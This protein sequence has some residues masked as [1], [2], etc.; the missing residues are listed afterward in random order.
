MD[1]ARRGRPVHPENAN[2]KTAEVGDFVDYT[3]SSTTFGRCRC[4]P[5]WSGQ[6]PAGFAYVRGT[7]R[8]TAHAVADPPAAPAPPCI[9]RG[10]IAVGASPS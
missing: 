7:A 2:K 5:P 8:L 4:P 6:L 3:S 9:R 1:P 10:H